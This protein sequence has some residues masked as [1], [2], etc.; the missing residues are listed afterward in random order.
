[1]ANLIWFF[2]PAILALGTITSYQDIK[3]GKIRNR[4]ILAALAYAVIVNAAL[5]TYYAT[6]GG[7]SGGYVAELGTNLLFAVLAGFGFWIAGIW[8]AGDGKL[9]IAFAAL[10]P[11]SSYSIGYQ[12][13]VPSFTLSVNIFAAAILIMLI[14]ALAKIKAKSLAAFS[15]K[16]FTEFFKPTTLFKQVSALFAISWAVQAALSYLKVT[17]Y[18]LSMAITLAA[19]S[20]MA[21]KTGRRATYILLLACLARLFLDKSI[22][23][24]EFAVSFAILIVTWR[25]IFGF[26][27][28][29]A[30]HLAREAFTKEIPAA[31]LK[32]GM[33]L[34]D[35][36]KAIGEKEAKE[37]QSKG[38]KVAVHKGGYYAQTPKSAFA[39]GN[40]IDEEAEGL[41]KE[42]I[43]KI[44]QAGI[45]TVRV[46]QTM[47][48][49]PF[50]FL[51]V[52]ITIT[53][54]GNILIVV[55]LFF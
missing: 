6:H 50:I 13:W 25:L 4:W 52:L 37:M 12:K 19:Y 8:T 44:R 20:L 26:F 30:S 31:R 22:Y 54:H 7:V 10:I 14:F 9:F 24:Q 49:A 53:A 45:K 42:Q 3:Y 15:R 17:S 28:G 34:S 40:F 1:M 51:G 16:F 18:T 35:S 55:R 21:K 32:P 27:S 47:P 11:L 43:K 2:L 39:A 48:F 41:T 46:S 33:V 23:T 36:I 5:I 29:G 38:A